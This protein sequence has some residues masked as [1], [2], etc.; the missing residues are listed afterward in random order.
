MPSLYD[1]LKSAQPIIGSSKKKSAYQDCLIEQHRIHLGEVPETLC[2][3][4]AFSYI[5]NGAIQA[6][7]SPE[8]L[9][10]LDTETTG[11]SR[12]AGTVAFLIGFGQIEGQDLI[13]TQV[14]MRDYPQESLLLKD[15][16]HRIEASQCLVTYNGSSF[17]L[18]LL[19][20]RLTMNRLRNDL[21]MKPH[22]DLLHA[23]RRIFKLR[24]GRCPLTRMEE[25]V[26]GFVREGDLPGAE[27]PGRYF[28]YLDSQDE[29]LLRA[30]LNHNCQD[31]L[32]LTRLFV[33]ISGLHQNPLNTAY[34]QD[35]FSLGRVYE[36]QGHQSRAIACYK[37]CSEK[38]V[39]GLARLRMAELYRRQKMDREAV[40]QFETLRKSVAVSA[41]VYISLAKI[42]EHRFHEPLRALEITRQGMLYCSE[43][44]GFSPTEDTDYLDLQRRCLRL[45]RKVERIS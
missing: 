31:I 26:F 4:Q 16:L 39:I 12:G 28:S 36:Q 2:S 23:A 29:S 42:Y 45:M 19:Q 11:L 32:T 37:A 6:D 14:L 7:F 41:R 10:F 21:S 24:V 25:L 17:D 22:L 9:L 5:S 15:M 35:L 18:P 27:V 33:H 38:T 43:R 8:S 34:Q 40:E 13:V 1:K 3:S 20:G 30:I 44:L